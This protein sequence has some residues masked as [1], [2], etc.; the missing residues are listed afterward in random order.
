[1]KLVLV[2]DNADFVI[3]MRMLLEMRG[4]DVKVY[5][6]AQEFLQDVASLDED[7][8]LITDYYLPDLN[9]IEVVRRA[10][11][12]RPGLRAIL[13]TGSREDSVVRAARSIA[14]RHHG[15]LT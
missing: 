2:D 6:T 12:R 5:L 7:D 11:A 14:R 15:E 9:G 1:M 3:S 8:L 13:L 10:R 4:Y